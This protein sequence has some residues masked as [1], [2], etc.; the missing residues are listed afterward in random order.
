MAGFGAASVLGLLAAPLW[1]AVKL[2]VP[3]ASVAAPWYYAPALGFVAIGL[4]GGLLFMVALWCRAGG[5][6]EQASAQARAG[7]LRLHVL[8][9]AGLAAVPLGL[10]PLAV[11]LEAGLI[12]DVGW[13]RWY[14]PILI[15]VA[16]MACVGVVSAC[17]LASRPLDAPRYSR[18]PLTSG[19]DGRLSW[20]GCVS[21]NLA[22]PLYA[23]GENL[24]TASLVP[25]LSWLCGLGGVLALVLAFYC[26][27]KLAVAKRR[28]GQRIGSDI[29][30]RLG[31][32][33]IVTCISALA[34]LTVFAS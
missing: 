18:E 21:G 25:W 12:P 2:V 33:G 8:A 10:S 5:K 1:A 30:V 16:L 29:R 26:L 23:A 14:G 9:A 15:G 31:F 7:P 19:N 17:R 28:R 34:I 32:E 4:P 24:G 22:M 27:G 11:G 6:C 3:V 13:L 20:I